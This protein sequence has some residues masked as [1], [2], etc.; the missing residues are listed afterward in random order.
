MNLSNSACHAGLG[1]VLNFSDTDQHTMG[2]LL[3]WVYGGLEA[4]PSLAEAEAL[5]EAAHKYDMPE[6][7]HRCEQLMAEHVN[8]RSYPER[9]AM[10]SSH[11][12]SV[13][14]QVTI[15]LAA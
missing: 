6:L 5:F 15:P 11:H 10:A 9:V 12:A 2:L 8:L 7:Q 13:L 1:S 4:V 3:E 14:Q